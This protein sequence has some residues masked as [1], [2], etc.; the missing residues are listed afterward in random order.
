VK[1]LILFFVI[2]THLVFAKDFGTRGHVFSIQEQDLLEYLKNKLNTISP[3]G[4]TQFDEKIQRHYV[5]MAKEPKCLNIGVS[6]E[7]RTYYFDPSITASKDIYDH[8]GNIIVSM[9]S[10]F[11][12]LSIISLTQDLLFID[13]SI[14]THVNWAKEQALP[15]RWIIIKGKPLE[16]EEQE[17]RPIYFDQ[18]GFLTS[19]LEIK[20]IP[21]RVT[22]ENNQL[23][24][25]EIPL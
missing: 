16:L 20:N 21:A 6:S 17:E 18:S 7:Y 8:Q 24:I 5:N 15:N 23:K 22:Q 4:E 2:I 19:K 3:R 1:C 10:R 11:N 12:P 25:E 14:E 9:G 13:G